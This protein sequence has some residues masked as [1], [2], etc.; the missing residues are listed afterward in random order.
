MAWPPD[1][2]FIVCA[3]NGG[4]NLRRL[5]GSLARSE[6]LP[7]FSAR[8]VPTGLWQ[9]HDDSVTVPLTGKS[10]DPCVV[11]RPSGCILMNSF[12][13]TGGRPYRGG[14]FALF[15]LV[16]SRS[17]A[18]ACPADSVPVGPACVDKYESSAWR[19]ARTSTALIA[20]VRAGTVT[21]ADLTARGAVQLGLAKGDLAAGGCPATGNRCR[22]VYAVS[23]PGAKPAAYVNWFQAVA[24]ARNSGK[25][26]LTNQEWQAAAFGTRDPGNTPGTDDCNTA[27]SGTVPTGSR[28]RCASEVGAYDMVGNV[29]EWIADLVP[30]STACVKPLFR[31]GDFNCV[32]GASATAGPGAV[33]RGGGFDNGLAGGAAAGVFTIDGTVQPTYPSGSPDPAGITT[34]FRCGR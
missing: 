5:P 1:A 31:T 30:L 24:M 12:G 13:N 33:F 19:I 26:L 27:S 14:T 10:C 18:A 23:I 9:H 4:V 32:A 22:D 6:S 20:K 17:G 16:I 11:I 3:L 34:G 15:S 2:R 8:E 7:A 28:S 21:L 29:W 25:R